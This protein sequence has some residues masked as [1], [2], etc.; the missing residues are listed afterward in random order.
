MAKTRVLF[1]VAALL[2]VSMPAFAAINVIAFDPSNVVIIAPKEA[3]VSI[4]SFEGF[5]DGKKL[6]ISVAF[7]NETESA[8]DGARVAMMVFDDERNV[9]GAAS[10]RAAGRAEAGKTFSAAFEL[11][12]IEPI[13]SAWQVIV[14]PV[15]ASL[16]EESGWRVP[17]Q[18][19]RPLVDR[20]RGSRWTGAEQALAIGADLIPRGELVQLLPPNCTL[21][22]CA[23]NNSDCYEYCYDLIACAYCDRRRTGEGCSTTCYC[24]GPT[25]EC[26]PDPYQ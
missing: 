16:T 20:L 21:G 15:E 18:A 11:P 19:L 13:D 22:Q 26:P 14:V 24:I 8:I 3:P 2:L 17:G 9:I 10:H 5:S 23:A 25:Q 12:L 7:R 4:A 6:S 1:S